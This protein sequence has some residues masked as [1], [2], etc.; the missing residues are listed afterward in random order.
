LDAARLHLV[1]DEPRKA[2]K[3]LE[4]WLDT[5]F[6][7]ERYYEAVY[8][9]GEAHFQLR[10]YWKAYERF[11]EAVENTAGELFH[12]SLQREIDVARAFLSGEKRVL[13]KVFRLPAQDDGIEILDRVWERAP[14]TRLGEA[15]IKLKA[16]YF[17][18]T[19]DVDLAQDEY[20]A[21]ARDYPS[22]KYT[23]LAMMRSAE[24]AEAAFQGIAFS[25]APLI[26]AQERYLQVQDVFPAYAEREDVGPR[27]EGIRDQRAEKD[28]AV[29]AWYERTD[30]A[31]AA[32]YYYRL[33][34]RDY[35]ETIAATEAQVR[36]R[37]LGFDPPEETE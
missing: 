12:K 29:G 20:V 34:I 5:Q 3:L 24:S 35:A 26:E 22:G 25:D 13:W 16:D 27:L 4:D 32:A 36:L 10:D 1:Q 8:L 11:D 7:D 23:A 14:G 19:G 17:F 31:G 33:V 18:E 15:A 9:L 37:A 30:Q 2:K 28:L 21:L 6:G